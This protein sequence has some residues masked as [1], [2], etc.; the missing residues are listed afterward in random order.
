MS[1]RETWSLLAGEYADEVWAG[2]GEQYYRWGVV[3][4]QV[5]CQPEQLWA[6]PKIFTRPLA[7]AEEERAARHHF[8]LKNI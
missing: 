8:S 3:L 5:R 4:G 1:R 7:A 6:H 2:G